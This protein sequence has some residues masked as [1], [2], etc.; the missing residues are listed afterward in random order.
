MSL[1]PPDSN[2]SVLHTDE[3]LSQPRAAEQFE[4]LLKVDFEPAKV[5]LFCNDS[6]G[7]EIVRREGDPV[8]YNCRRVESQQDLNLILISWCEGRANRIVQAGKVVDLEWNKHFN[9]LIVE[10]TFEMDEG[11]R[12]KLSQSFQEMFKD[13]PLYARDSLDL[14]WESALFD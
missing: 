8:V 13:D 7:V 5:I 11:E 9:N 1:R 6:N 2:T 4:K 3:V 10:V 14:E 12:D